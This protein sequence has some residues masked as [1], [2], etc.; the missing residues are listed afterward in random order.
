MYI[1]LRNACSVHPCIT[2]N[3]N[4]QCLHVYVAQ[5]KPYTCTYCI[6]ICMWLVFTQIPLRNTSSWQLN[7][8]RL[9]WCACKGSHI[10]SDTLSWL[11]TSLHLH[12]YSGISWSVADAPKHETLPKRKLFLANVL[13]QLSA[14]VLVW[15]KFRIINQSRD[16]CLEVINLHN[17]SC[18]IHSLVS[19]GWRGFELV[20]PGNGT[21]VKELTYFSAFVCMNQDVPMPFPWSH[22]VDRTQIRISKHFPKPASE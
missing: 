12:A 18:I 15:L 22:K 13:R 14:P 7:C 11:S 3:I 19:E 16:L 1:I 20:L 17:R 9:P 5:M 2:P 10:V 4:V 21:I 6:F 8:L